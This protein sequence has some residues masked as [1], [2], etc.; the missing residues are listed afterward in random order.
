MSEKT[1]RIDVIVHHLHDKNLRRPTR[2]TRVINMLDTNEGG[3]LTSVLTRP[4]WPK[5]S[6][7]STIRIFTFAISENT[8]ETSVHSE[9]VG[10]VDQLSIHP[11]EC[12]VFTIDKLATE[13]PLAG[14]CPSLVDD[15][16]TNMTDSANTVITEAENPCNFF[17]PANSSVR[18]WSP[19][20]PFRKF[21]EKNL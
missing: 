13:A 16:S 3:K 5:S 21:L 2:T 11:N 9:E 8:G 19:S 17:E 6:K 14:V 4:L 12:S 1:H 20:D 7:V 10:D 15:E 18:R